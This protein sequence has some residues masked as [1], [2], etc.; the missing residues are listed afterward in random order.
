MTTSLP[1]NIT[2]NSSCVLGNS[3][4]ASY[5]G[6]LNQRPVSRYYYLLCCY[7]ARQPNRSYGNRTHHPATQGSLAPCM[8]LNDEGCAPLRLTPTRFER[9]TAVLETADLTSLVHGA[10]N[11][12]RGNRT[13]SV[14][15]PQN[16]QSRQS[17]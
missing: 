7:M 11:G 12:S 5:G 14:L 1:R 4:C 2:I 15:K 8:L 10:K 17:P 16:L 13:H 6:D 9:V 3:I